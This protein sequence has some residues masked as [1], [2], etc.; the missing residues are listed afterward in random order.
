MKMKKPA[1]T[2]KAPAMIAPENRVSEIRRKRNLSQKRL[3]ELTGIDPTILN[4]IE[5]RLRHIGGEE[6]LGLSR[7]LKAPT[8]EILPVA[9]A[10]PSAEFYDDIRMTGVIIA[11]L[12]AYEKHRTKPDPEEVAELVSFLYQRSIMKRLSVKDVRDLASS[13]VKA[14]KNGDKSDSTEFDQAV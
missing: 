4:R 9:N 1:K 14:G 7:V 11:V 12:E 13:H 8:F 10:A 5:K 6:L 2:S 3:A